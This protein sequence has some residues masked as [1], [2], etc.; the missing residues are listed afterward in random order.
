MQQFDVV[1]LGGGLIGASQALCLAKSCPQLR[2]AVVEAFTA[3]DSAQ[4]SFDDRSIA[5]AHHSAKYLSKLGLFNQSAPYVETIASVQVSDRG[6]FGKTNISAAE[7]QVPAL[8]YVAE[9]RPFGIMLHQQLVQQGIT[10]FCPHTVSAIELSANVNILTLNDNQQLSAKLVIVADG[11]Q[12]TSRAMLK[13]DFKPESYPQSAIIA[14]IEVSG[15]HHQRAFERFTEHGPMALLPMSQNRYSL[16][17]CVHPDAVADLMQASDD[18][19]LAQLQKAFGYRAGHFIKVG[20]KAQYPLTKGQAS[21]F[22]AHRTAI[23]GN[24][25]HTVHPIAGQGFNLGVRDIQLLVDLIKTAHN[26]GL[27]IGTYPVLKHYQQQRQQDIGTVLCLTDSLVKL[28]SNSAR[29][30]A[31]GRSIGL[32]SLELSKGLKKPLAKQLMGHTRQGLKT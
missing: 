26:Q 14:N 11:A 9:V 6:H 29:F 17:W 15:G 25:A 21:Q 20:V 24:A 28:F 1:I 32:L 22:I 8:G 7:Y 18:E 19:F 27:D 2:I 30:I 10:L 16:V 4:P 23:I 3:N 13:I 12:S 5:I 31:L